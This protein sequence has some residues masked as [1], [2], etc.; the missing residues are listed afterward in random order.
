MACYYLVISSTHLSNGHFRNIKGVFRGPLCKTAG[1]ESPDYA[2]K[3]KA[4]AKALEDLKANFYCEL[5]DKQ[6]HKHQEFDNHINSYDHAH[7]QRLKE[8]KQREFAR[9]VASKSWK[10][11]RKQERALRRLHQLAEQRQQSD[12]GPGSGPKFRTTT[13]SAKAQHQDKVLSEKDHA[14]DHRP[15][16]LAPGGVSKASRCPPDL[17][18]H[19]EQHHS[20]KRPSQSACDYSHQRAGVSFCFSRKAQLKLESSASVFSD[21]LEEASDREELQRQR[22][23]QTLEALWSRTPSLG[24][25]AADSGEDEE[26]KE[27]R[28]QKAG[29]QEGQKGVES[30]QNDGSAACRAADEP[31]CRVTA[32]PSSLDETRLGDTP[33]EF[34]HRP[35]P[36]GEFNERK[37]SCSLSLRGSI[38]TTD[39]PAEAEPGLQESPWFQRGTETIND[40]D[41]GRIEEEPL[42]RVYD[43]ADEKQIGNHI[44]F[45][46]VLSK[47][48]V[49]MLKWPTELLQYTK[50]KPC[51]SYS[52]NPLYFNFKHSRNRHKSNKSTEA[53]GPDHSDVESDVR[54]GEGRWSSHVRRQKGQ[55]KLGVPKPK[56]T[57]SHKAKKTR[58]LKSKPIAELNTSC[59]HNTSSH[60]ESVGAF[61][62][63]PP[64]A[65]QNNKHASMKRYR[66]G[67]RKRSLKDNASNESD[68]YSL[69]SVIS[70]VCTLLSKKKRRQSLILVASNLTEEFSPLAEK[71]DYLAYHWDAG[72]SRRGHSATS[73]SEKSGS[74]S[75]FSDLNSDSEGASYRYVKQPSSSG[76]NYRPSLRRDFSCSQAHGH[77]PSWGGMRSRRPTEK[78]S[79]SERKDTSADRN[80]T[81]PG[82]SEWPSV[83]EPEGSRKWSRDAKQSRTQG[84]S[85]QRSASSCSSSSSTFDISHQRAGGSLQALHAAA[86]RGHSVSRSRSR[87]RLRGLG[88]VTADSGLHETEFQSVSRDKLYFFRPPSITATGTVKGIRDQTGLQSISRK[89]AGT[90]PNINATHRPEEQFPGDKNFAGRKINN[91]LSLPL[92]GK[93]PA[94]K[95]STKKG[96]SG[97]FQSNLCN[98]QGGAAGSTDGLGGTCCPGP[99]PPAPG[100]SG[101][102][103][104]SSQRAKPRPEVMQTDRQSPQPNGTGELGQ[105]PE[106]F[107]SE[108]NILSIYS[109]ER[110]KI[111]TVHHCQ[112]QETWKSAFDTGIDCTEESESL[113][114]RAQKCVSPPLTEQPITFTPEEIDKYRHLQLQ[115]QQHMQQQLL[116]KQVKGIPETPLDESSLSPASHQNPNLL[117]T[118]QPVPL[119]QPGP[120]LQHALLHHRALAAF[121]SSLHPHSTHQRLA[122]HLHPLPQPHFTPIS[123]SH[124]AAVLPAHPPALL[125]G[126]PLHFIPASALHPAHLALHPLP[127]GS[128]LPTLLAPATAASTLHLRPLLHPLFPGQ[129]L[130]P[131]SGPNS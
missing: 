130:Q 91:S 84:R 48:G 80:K 45:L 126:H 70:P 131:H 2:E 74:C 109:A 122:H 89:R 71:E 28:A 96:V 4:I 37:M 127:P 9:N 129:D 117:P 38:L 77:K 31:G 110:E 23:R 16:P 57:K 81:P 8:L 124:M 83:D 35:G 51:V 95:K 3:E 82:I 65:L 42:G 13:V 17:P 56:K 101:L 114:E 99:H 123:I 104:L 94:V 72:D 92:I 15:V 87:S 90:P 46:N 115:A 1:N 6:Y 43:V 18:T 118:F 40:S 25:L 102:F 58:N 128:L 116:V 76:S 63:A 111:N 100:N 112:G 36:E 78:R 125:P 64:N 62:C 29:H 121:A 41:N 33:R 67:K 47:D 34:N 30:C 88:L 73:I 68:E 86:K 44:S 97:K 21:G 26:H 52:C 103:P 22:A 12:C 119:Q 59:M 61:E 107:S 27:A 39:Q 49:T 113:P 5:C 106:V 98:G 79:G 85:G 50:S 69:K 10:D 120:S 55:N 7:K 24:E 75:S 66:L 60:T 19:R 93:F 105:L 11:E 54:E 108:A 14:V 53:A 20:H 32:S